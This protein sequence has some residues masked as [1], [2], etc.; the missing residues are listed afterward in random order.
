VRTYAY[1]FDGSYRAALTGVT[2]DTLVPG[3][4]ECERLLKTYALFGAGF[5]LSDIQVVDNPV[6][7][8]QF[9]SAGFRRFL[10]GDRDFLH[11]A[12]RPLKETGDRWRL[13]ATGLE[14]AL[15][16]GRI[17]SPLHDP[18]S[19]LR[20]AEEIV[21]GG[22]HCDL[23]GVL[24]THARSPDAEPLE[25]F[26][27]LFRYF[28]EDGRIATPPVSR[29][30]GTYFEVLERA[31]EEPSLSGTDRAM[32]RATVDHI[33]NNIHDPEA[34]AKRHSVWKTLDLSRPRDRAMWKLV[35]QAW[36]V[37]AQGYVSPDGGLTSSLE[38]I[39]IAAYVNRPVELMLPRGSMTG[40]S[41]PAPRSPSVQLLLKWEPGALDWGD[42]ARVCE[43][44]SGAEARLALQQAL[45]ADQ[46]EAAHDAVRRLS[47]IV[48]KVTSDGIKSPISPW[49]WVVGEPLIL[50]WGRAAALPLEM[51]N[52]LTLAWAGG[53]AAE[54]SLVA[55]LHT[56]NRKNMAFRVTRAA[57]DTGVL[58]PINRG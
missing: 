43:D 23:T 24:H 52:A 37:A 32:V 47:D 9:R 57:R 10:A 49:V 3:D 38:D 31:L 1:W 33:T 27:E 8:R 41:Q 17:G 44:T 12:V 58:P 35:C 53:N 14:R 7:W 36:N 26:I 45:R 18:L 25:G 6:L 55:A 4:R 13:A 15:I 28:V 40:K 50:L 46:T 21:T 22:P 2:P 11:L 48:A 34:R 5:E 42:I 29:P 54:K 16:A 56:C 51:L 20:V 39:P 30:N 19:I